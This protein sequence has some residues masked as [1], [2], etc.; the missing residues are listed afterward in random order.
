MKSRVILRSAVVLV[1]FVAVAAG[2]AA[3]EVVWK[4]DFETNDISQFDGT[5]NA[6]KDARKNIEIVTM[7]RQQGKYAAKM[8]IHPDDTFKTRQMRVQFTRRPQRTEEGQD[9][10]MSFHLRMEEAPLVRDNFAYWESDTSW[11]N[12][13]TWWVAPKEGGGTT[14][15]F[16]TGNLGPNQHWS[17]D[18]SIKKWHQMVMHIHWSPD[19]Q[20]GRIK[21]WYDGKVVVDIKAVTK[22]DK[23]PMFFQPG[24][25]RADRTD[26]VDTIYFDNFIEADAL[27]DVMP[28]KP[29]KRR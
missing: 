11:K 29:S 20:V 28:V 17:A 3:A 6:T 25:H 4:A 21:L 10:F 27:A 13:M 14:I 9:L 15:N 23:N 7:P 12:V 5:M 18:F 1:G 19:P 2:P 16:G 22:P 24:I 8:T 26:A